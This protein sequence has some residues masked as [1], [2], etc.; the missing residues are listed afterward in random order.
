LLHEFKNRP[1]F[2]VQGLLMLQTYL[3]CCIDKI[4]CTRAR[5]IT[6]TIT[7]VSSI[8]SGPDLSF[9]TGLKRA[10]VRVPTV[11]QMEATECGAASLGMVPS[12]MAAMAA[13]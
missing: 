9:T 11:L 13:S 4:R 7:D 10:R 2:A 1:I 8:E 5:E 6:V 12:A 3:S